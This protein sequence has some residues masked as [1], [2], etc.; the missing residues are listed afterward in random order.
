MTN[1]IKLPKL[2]PKRLSSVLGLS[3]DGNRLE[4]IVLRRTNGSL[5]PLQTATLSLSLD[6]L[7]ADPLLVGREIRN[8]LQAA[9]IRERHCVLA[10]PL[11]WALTAHIELPELPEADLASFIA[12]EAERGFPCDASTLLTSTSRCEPKEG[13]K[14]ATVVGI[15]RAHLVRMEQVL[16]AAKLNPA[17]FGLGMLALGLPGVETD[18][19]MLSLVIGE[20]NVGLQITCGDGIA[21][22]RT[23]EGALDLEGGRRILNAQVVAREA[24]ITL[25]QL[26]AE[27]RSTVRTVRIFGSRDLA[28]QLADEIELRLESMGLQV[29]MVTRYTGKE[30]GPLLPH[31]TPVSPALGLAAQYLTVSKPEFNFLPP[32]VTAWKLLSKRYSSGKLRFAGA[33]AAAVI[34][35]VILLFG[36]QQIQLLTARSQ[37]KRISVKVQEL[38]KVQDQ[39]RLY[40]GWFDQ[41]LR[42]MT[43]LRQL[44]MAFPETGSVSAKTIEFREPD[45]VTCT[46]LAVDNASLLRTVDHIRGLD[47][48]SDLNVSTIRGKSPLQ[49]TFV[50]RWSE[51][52][53]HEN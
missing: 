17:G 10:L 7:T 46:G 47:N 11:K 40:R 32:R 29:E 44:T 28:Q 38:T 26:P 8:Q 48:V 16:R 14:F 42:G 52:G 12:I 27:L 5:Q 6:P 45:S 3:L 15:P 1:V 53:K 30:F 34:L 49:F 21:A 37:W 41:N 20:T 51:G 23:V 9:G 13:K 39:V 18:K 31:D 4:A 36:V 33:A 2:G 24:R 19:G 35:V 43:I 50:F 22:L 25:G